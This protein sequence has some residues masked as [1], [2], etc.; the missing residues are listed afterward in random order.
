MT[1]KNYVN[2]N[3]TSMVNNLIDLINIPTLR[4]EPAPG[5]PF[6]ENINKGLEYLLDLA[7]SF[8]LEVKNYDGYA[9]EINLGTGDYIIGILG[10]VDVVPVGDGWNTDPFHAKIIDNKIYGRGSMDDKAPII[11]CLHVLKYLKDNNLVPDGVTYRMIIGTNEEEDWLCV[12]HYVEVVDRLPDVSIVPDANFP[13]I[14]CEKGLLDFNLYYQ[15]QTTTNEKMKVHALKGG[16]AR[17]VVT[18][19]AMCLIEV[20]TNDYDTLLNSLNDLD[21]VTATL[22]DHLWTINTLG[23]SCHAM[24]PEKGKNAIAILMNALEKLG[25]DFPLYDFVKLYNRVIGFTYNGENFD[26]AFEDHVSGKLTFNVGEILLAENIISLISNVR[27]PAS[28]DKDIVINAVKGKATK[29]N[30]DYELIDHMD[31]ICMDMDSELITKLMSA[32]VKETGDTENKPFSIGG[33]TYART[34]PNAVA[35][36]PLFP[37]EE[38]LAHEDNEFQDIESFEKMTYIYADALQLLGQRN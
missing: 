3:K 27:Y 31:A 6:G 11:S 34:I 16:I 35:F 13:A 30:L 21:G 18:E 24:S 10:H 7:A 36:G 14:F 1:I 20:L 29:L 37:W 32:Y 4:G 38:E 25:Q 5:A 8:G 17:N 22:K 28:C 33:A 26:C 2:E 9:G 12:K 19:K 23:K 15:V